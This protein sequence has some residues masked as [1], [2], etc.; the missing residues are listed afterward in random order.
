MDIVHKSDR[1]YR[2]GKYA[3]NKRTD[4]AL[5]TKAMRDSVLIF[6]FYLADQ[7][8]LYDSTGTTLIAF[9]PNRCFRR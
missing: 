9:Q 5:E 3:N 1:S 7:N 2:H 6:I 8:G 4:V